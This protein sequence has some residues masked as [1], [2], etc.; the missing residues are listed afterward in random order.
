MSASVL[1]E[2]R[3]GGAQGLVCVARDLTGSKALE[4]E[5]FRLMEAVQRQAIMV[6]ELSA[7]LLPISLFRKRTKRGYD[8]L[9]I[10]VN[11]NGSYQIARR[12]GG[13]ANSHTNGTLTPEQRR[14]LSAT[15]AGWDELETIY[16]NPGATEEE[17]QIEIKYGDKHVVASDAA[18]NL[19]PKFREA[20]RLLRDLLTANGM[21]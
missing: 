5:R 9:H 2:K 7:P 1:R 3:R 17:F 13:G 18:L 8:E 12:G 19:P 11:P 14:N 4:D 10:T 6:E 15:F 20:Y 16:P 21:L